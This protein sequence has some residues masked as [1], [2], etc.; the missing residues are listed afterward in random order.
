[1][2]TTSGGEQKGAAVEAGSF[3]RLV[4]IMGLMAEGDPAAVVMLY[5]EFGNHIAA[6]VRRQLR[7]QGMVDIEPDELDGLLWDA[8]LAI[9]SVG[10]GWDPDGG[11]LP[12]NWASLRVMNIVTDWVGQ[13]H[14]RLDE[15]DLAQLPIQAPVPCLDADELDVLAE[16]ATCHDGCGLL[17]EALDRVANRR[18][19]AVL[20]EYQVQ[21]SEG[22]PSPSHTVAARHGLNPENVRQIVSRTRRRLRALSAT[23]RRYEALA[24]L[25][26]LA[27]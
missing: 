19:Q 10:S 17:A 2:L 6:S 24:R 13:H 11:A 1:M 5:G 8:C 26:L 21:A 23:D 18:D 27:A 25:P 4:R 7:R 14:D 9:E 15:W 16:L 20:V 12:W 22:D 3:D